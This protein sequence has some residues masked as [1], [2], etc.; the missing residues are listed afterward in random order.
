MVAAALSIISYFIHLYRG[1]EET[2][3]LYCAFTLIAVVLIMCFLSYKQ[4]KKALQVGWGK[5][6]RT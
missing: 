2:I 5:E 6:N 4:E 3:N 1:N